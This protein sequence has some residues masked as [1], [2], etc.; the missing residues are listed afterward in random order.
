MLKHLNQRPIRGLYLDRGAPLSHRKHEDCRANAIP[1]AQRVCDTWR[2]LLEVLQYPRV[3]TSDSYVEMYG[4][5]RNFA[6]GKELRIE[7]IISLL[8]RDGRTS[9]IR[10]HTKGRSIRVLL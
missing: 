7:Q 3:V 9:G 6:P 10:H 1:D 8:R 2:A 4:F 5:R